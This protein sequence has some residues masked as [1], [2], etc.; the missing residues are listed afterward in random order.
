MRVHEAARRRM[1]LPTLD[2]DPIDSYAIRWMIADSQKP[3]S[4]SLTRR[5]SEMYRAAVTAMSEHCFLPRS[6][7]RPWQIPARSDG[8]DLAAESWICFLARSLWRV[9]LGGGGK[10]LLEF[11][12]G[13]MPCAM[14][15]P[16]V[17]LSRGST[18]RHFF[19]WSVR[20]HA[21]SPGGFARALRLDTGK[22]TDQ[23]VPIRGICAEARPEDCDG[24][25][26]QC[27]VDQSAVVRS[28]RD[29]PRASTPRTL[30]HMQ[31]AIFEFAC[32]LH[33]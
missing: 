20:Y 19:L 32:A 12:F 8:A 25:A 24:S 7:G 30:E 3:V 15:A 21:H 33:Q 23:S 26:A 14:R 1:V 6:L 22:G 29:T 5:P 16:E 31:S 9:H 13:F 10:R 4:T 18:M 2:D 17:N 27:G 11:G 28:G